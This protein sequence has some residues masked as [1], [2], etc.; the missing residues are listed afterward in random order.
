MQDSVAK[1]SGAAPPAKIA[2]VT[3]L[4]RQWRSGDPAALDR[5]LP[6]VY[7]EL[8]R[9]AQ[10]SMR[11][12]RADITL[13]PTALVAEAY[14]R[15]VDME[16]AW[17]DRVHFFAVAA[18]LMRRILV[19]EAR[20][21]QAQ[22]RGG[23]DKALS[24][25]ELSIQGFELADPGVDTDLMLLDQALTRLEEIDARKGKVVE[26]RCFAGMTIEETAQALGVSHATVERDLKMAKAWLAK[27]M[28]A[29]APPGAT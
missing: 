6:L 16:V 29:G 14:L 19:D 25:E 17:N 22:K 24:L 5:L 20:R 15:L 10:R 2:E 23:A 3:R 4:L 27:E 28:Q 7:E 18:N 11:G 9:L 13:Q 8:R 12:E 26:L 21:R 1:N